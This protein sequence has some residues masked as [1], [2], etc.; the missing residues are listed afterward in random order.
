M[1]YRK[2]RLSGNIAAALLFATSSVQAHVA[3]QGSP[4]PS[5]QPPEAAAAQSSSQASASQQAASTASNDSRQSGRSQET[6]KNNK[7]TVQELQTV[8]V[9]G[10]R[11]SLQQAL[12]IKRA[13]NSIVDAVTS[14][15]LGKLT[16]DAVTPLWLG[17]CQRGAGLFLDRLLARTAGW[18][19]L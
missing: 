10:I 6:R 9:V 16:T 3:Q 7:A 8:Q 18:G 11:A 12:E 5:G 14:E 15:D 13:A 1:T 4:G 19:R 2:T 17:R